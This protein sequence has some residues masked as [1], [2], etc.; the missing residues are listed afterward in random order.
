MDFFSRSINY[1]SVNINEEISMNFKSSNLSMTCDRA[2]SKVLPEDYFYTLVRSNETTSFPRGREKCGSI[3]NFLNQQYDESVRYN[4]EQAKIEKKVLVNELKTKIRKI[5]N[6]KEVKVKECLKKMFGHC[7]SESIIEFVDHF[8]K[9]QKRHVIARFS[10]LISNYHDFVRHVKIINDFTN[11]EFEGENKGTS[12]LV[13]KICQKI[14]LGSPY[15]DKKSS[16]RTVENNQHDPKI[17]G[18]EGKNQYG[19]ESVENASIVIRNLF[20][21]KEEFCKF[22]H[23]HTFPFPSMFTWSEEKMISIIYE[24]TQKTIEYLPELDKKNNKENKNS[25]KK[26]GISSKIK[27]VVYNC[28][29]KKFISRYFFNVIRSKNEMTDFNKPSGNENVDEGLINAL[30]NISENTT[31]K[32]TFIFQSLLLLKKYHLR[33]FSETEHFPKIIN[34]NHDSLSEWTMRTKNTTTLDDEIFQIKNQGQYKEDNDYNYRTYIAQKILTLIENQK[35]DRNSVKDAFKEYFSITIKNV[36]ENLK[37]NKEND[38]F[39]DIALIAYK[40]FALQVK[41]GAL[42]GRLC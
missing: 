21:F 35:F 17:M 18:Y 3:K 6:E 23:C 8:I 27:P 12:D 34:N 26:T 14:I 13:L 7:E 33:V 22:E 28:K 5:D 36:N 10:R 37:V 4:Y 41:Q 40:I 38:K 39:S 2:G 24:Q 29:N 32:E 11:K 9:E 25:N 42:I 19:K 1:S 20:G 31:D 30:K 16:N 15:S